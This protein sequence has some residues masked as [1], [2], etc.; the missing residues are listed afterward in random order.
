M[1]PYKLAIVASHPIQYQAPLFKAI[2]ES[3]EFDLTVYFAG[4]GNAA[5]EAYDPEFG[6]DIKWD[7]PL[8]EGYRHEFLDSKFE[9][10]LRLLLRKTPIDAVLILGWNSPEF[11]L[12]FLAATLSRVPIFL[13]A[14]SPLKQEL[15]KKGFAQPIKRFV[16]CVLFRFVSAFL[17]IGKE[18]KEFY[19][20]LGAPS[21]KLFFTPYAVDN[22]RFLN[23]RKRFSPQRSELRKEF[24]ISKSASV[25]LFVGKFIPKKRPLDLLRAYAALAADNK[26][27]V[28]VGEGQ[29]LGAMKD[30][31]R[32]NK[33]N[34]VHFVG[35]KNQTEVGKY[36]AMADIFVLPSGI[37]ETWGLVVNEAMCFG[38]PIVVS[39]VVGCAPDLVIPGTTG[40]TFPLGDVTNLTVVLNGL[41]RDTETRKKLGE[42]A[43]RRVATYRFEEDI[44]G[45]QRAFSGIT[46]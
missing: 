29:L 6:R 19:E 24:D 28:F 3:G 25:I 30:F 42:E 8:L 12:A 18:N 40:Y 27:L 26:A 39:D 7:I 15:L 1:K 22:E 4:R 31:V 46:L 45:I 41:L 44:K 23:D 16:L 33:L 21:R 9:L 35:F 14:E 32:E 2:A 11:L 37:G 5:A 36:Y 38:L 10:P 13:R 34:D 43:V 17:Y 20:H